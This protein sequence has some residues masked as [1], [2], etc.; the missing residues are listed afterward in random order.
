MKSNKDI[1]NK[2]RSSY[3]LKRIFENINQK[4]RLE[5]IKY[6]KKFQKRLTIKLKDYKKYSET[7][8]PI[9]IE[10]IHTPGIYGNFIN[11]D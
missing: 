6:N 7:Y 3:I 8:T 1:L 10:I 2:I 4:N 5:L 9:E 11:F